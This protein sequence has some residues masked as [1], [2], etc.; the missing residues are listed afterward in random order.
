VIALHFICDY[1]VSCVEP[2]SWL[3]EHYYIISPVIIVT[4]FVAERFIS[5]YRARLETRKKWY[6]DILVSP[7]TSEIDKFILKMIAHYNGAVLLSKVSQNDT[8]LKYVRELSIVTNDFK[9]LKRDFDL[10]VIYPIRLFYP[11]T[12]GILNGLLGNLE[13]YYVEILDAENRTTK[14]E[15]SSKLR[16]FKSDF[17]QALYSPLK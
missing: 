8:H 13:D 3:E 6:L 16:I 9:N 2:K 10:S 4:L 5:S 12:A 17:I 14:E 11:E 1:Q 7:K 15:L